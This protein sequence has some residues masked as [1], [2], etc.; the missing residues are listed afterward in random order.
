MIVFVAGMPRSGSTFTFNII[1]GLLRSRG[2]THQA[3]LESVLL[4]LE[5]A[6]SADHVI[7]KGH[8]ADEIT[9]KLVKLGAVK[10]VCSVRRPEDAIASWMDSFGFTVEE[11]IAAMDRW[12]LLYRQLRGHALSIPFETIDTDPFGAAWKIAQYVCPDSKPEDVDSICRA[13]TKEKVRRLSEKIAGGEGSIEDIGFSQYDRETF[14]HRR[15]VTS[16]EER[17]AEARIG[18][19]QIDRIRDFLGPY[20]DADGNLK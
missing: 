19:G 12:L 16:L 1:R 9:V 7:F 3:A 2:R 4:A 11:S 17:K 6:G 10:A 13:F 20:C 14:F 8:G 18:S 5:E 15:H